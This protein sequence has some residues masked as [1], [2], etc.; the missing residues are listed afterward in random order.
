[1]LPSDARQALRQLILTRLESSKLD[2]HGNPSYRL[3]DAL[4][5]FSDQ[6]WDHSVVGHAFDTAMLAYE[7]NHPKEWSN[8]NQEWQRKGIK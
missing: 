2:W 4:Q 1:M 8:A 5:D 7:E 6:V 3:V